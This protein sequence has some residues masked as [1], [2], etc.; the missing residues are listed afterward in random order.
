MKPTIS[1]EIFPPKGNNDIQTLYNTIDA[2]APLRPDFISVTYGAG[3]SNQQNTLE[4]ATV[5]RNKYRIRPVA[6]L[7]CVGATR[8]A[9]DKILCDLKKA[10]IRHILALRGD[11]QEGITLGEFQYASD[12]VAYIKQDRFFTVVGACYPEKHL[13]AYSLESDLNHLKY[14]V[15]CG[16]SRL[17][18]QLFFDNEVFYT[19]RERVRQKGIDVPIIAGIM[20]ITSA[21]QLERMVTMCGAT[22]PT[23]VQR[24]VKAYAHNAQAL[25]EAGIAYATTQIVD[26]LANGVDGV[27]IYTMNQADVTKKIMENIH[28]IAYVIGDERD[29]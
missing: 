13:E 18:S 19:W 14:K 4:L 15:D 3:G 25:K 6:H 10:G 20:P 24:F 8:E 17:V 21:K 12:L 22:I 9:I 2:L 5:L 1:F 26:L 23:Q 27:H 16:T 7:T 11:L 29:I 28:A